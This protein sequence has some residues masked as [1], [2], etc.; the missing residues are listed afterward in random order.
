MNNNETIESWGWNRF[1]EKTSGQYIRTGTVRGR[2]LEVRRADWLVI[3]ESPENT[4]TQYNA[5]VSGTLA[6][7]AGSGMPVTGDWV[8]LR[9]PESG[10]PGLITA[11]LPRYSKFSRKAPGDVDHDRIQEQIIAANIDT[12]F[13]VAAAGH[14]WNP[15]RIERYV[16]LAWESGASPVLVI[17][18]ADIAENLDELIAEGY[19]AAPGIPVIPVSAKTGIGITDLTAILT[20]GKTAVL[21]GSSGAGKSTLLN[22]LAGTD[23]QQTREVRADDHRGRH[24]TTARTL[25]RLASGALIIDTP[26]LREIQLWT[27]AKGV[28]TA[29]EDVERFASQ[30][31][32]RNCGHTGEPGCAVQ[33]ALESGDLPADRYNRWRKLRREADYLERKTNKAAELAERERWK[34]LTKTIRHIKKDTKGLR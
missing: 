24:T 34:D 25:F 30:C 10:G 7:D 15:G 31:R 32:F 22:A 26:G 1:L 11:V 28:D 4:M 29:F 3:A 6:R 14:D 16:T 27:D 17:T 13:I 8:T 12:V 2:I 19:T 5:A 23:L 33:A 18:K 21:L 9:L 20:A